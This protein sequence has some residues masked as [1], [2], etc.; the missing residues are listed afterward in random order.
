VIS[1][2]KLG[3]V[4]K[5]ASN[6]EQLALLQDLNSQVKSSKDHMGEFGQANSDDRAVVLDEDEAIGSFAEELA[7]EALDN[8]LA[9][10]QIG[11]DDDKEEIVLDNFLKDE[12]PRYQP[13][14]ANIKV[15][16]PLNRVASIPLHLPKP[17]TGPQTQVTQKM[18]PSHPI[19]GKKKAETT[20]QLKP[21]DTGDAYRLLSDKEAE[22][23]GLETQL[24]GIAGLKSSLENE[25]SLVKKRNAQ[26]EAE[27]EEMR[28]Q[29][30]VRQIALEEAN[31]AKK[32][33]E[34]ESQNKTRLLKERQELTSRSYINT[35]LENQ[36]RVYEGE[37]EKRNMRIEMLEGNLKAAEDRLK[38]T[39]TSLTQASDKQRL[40]KLRY[41]LW[42]RKF[43]ENRL[44]RE[45]GCRRGRAQDEGADARAPAGT[46]GGVQRTTRSGLRREGE[47]R[48]RHDGERPGKRERAPAQGN[49]EP[50]EHLG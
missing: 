5:S 17:S 32:A 44:L 48:G 15:K 7:D 37:I 49:R 3:E 12:E 18:I 24:S 8:F 25:L 39:Y 29:I 30:E 47:H 16:A 35:A 28:R 34:L 19:Q 27:K 38:L 43:S 6:S 41:W 21:N 26:L 23:V 36:R 11:R 40:R 9:Q 22:I 33:A 42:N 46:T 50:Q 20:Y 4:A 45:Q 31:L 13:K 10:A 14:Q 1:K 2:V